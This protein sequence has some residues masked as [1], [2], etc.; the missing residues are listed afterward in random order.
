MA[1]NLTDAEKIRLRKIYEDEKV[2]LTTAGITSIDPAE[3]LIDKASAAGMQYSK[4]AKAYL[5]SLSNDEVKK[6]AQDAEIIE[7]PNTIGAPGSDDSQKIG[8][9]DNVQGIKVEHADNTKEQKAEQP[10]RKK[11]RLEEAFSME[12]DGNGKTKISFQL[13]KND[14]EFEDLFDDISPRI[15]NEGVK[16]VVN[17]VGHSLVNSLKSKVTNRV[18]DVL[19][20]CSENYKSTGKLNQKEQE[21]NN[22]INSLIEG[23]FKNFGF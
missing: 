15:K 3:S 19:N 22:S 17:A 14:E 5:K 18:N 6:N 4:A 11:F 20:N 16:G 9:S 12:K 13:P 10:A 8:E 21:F 2:K 7:D 1:K 23:V